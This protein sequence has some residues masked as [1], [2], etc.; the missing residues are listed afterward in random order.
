MGGLLRPTGLHDDAPRAPAEGDGCR[1]RLLPRRAPRTRRGLPGA[2][3]LPRRAA[4]GGSARG[5][6]PRER[7]GGKA[8]A[9]MSRPIPLGLQPLQASRGRAIAAAGT[10]RAAG[11]NAMTWLR[12]LGSQIGVAVLWTLHFLPLSLLSAMGATLGPIPYRFRRGRVTHVT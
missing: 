5:G 7:Q 2:F 8:R 10:F 12:Y 4:A 6:A 9:R 3:R 11:L 1:D